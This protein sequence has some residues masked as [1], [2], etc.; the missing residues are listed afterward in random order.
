[1]LKLN[2]MLKIISFC[3]T[4]LFTVLPT[5][6]QFAKSSYSRW[7]PLLWRTVSSRFLPVGWIRKNSTTSYKIN[8]AVDEGRQTKFTD[9]I[10][11]SNLQQQNDDKE[12]LIRMRHKL[13]KLD[14]NDDDYN[15]LI[16][17]IKK[18]VN[19]SHE[20]NNKMIEEILAKEREEMAR[21]FEERDAEHKADIEEINSRNKEEIQNLNAKHE[22]DFAAEILQLQEQHQNEIRMIL[23]E[24]E[25]ETGELRARIQQVRQIFLR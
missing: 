20:S 12:I 2:S 11:V 1:M 17:E 14:N 22:A 10:P 7:L 24:Y 21:K 4:C 13:Q 6:L 18:Q 3:S 15:P 8:P 23:T 9:N 19:E 16:A 25:R 5:T